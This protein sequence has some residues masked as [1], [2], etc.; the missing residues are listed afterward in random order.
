MQPLLA[1]C[2]TAGELCK[3]TVGVSHQNTK[4]K[5]F[6][7]QKQMKNKGYCDV[8]NLYIALVYS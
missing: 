4:N 5:V 3:Q 6:S 2:Q 8:D 7:D 1:S